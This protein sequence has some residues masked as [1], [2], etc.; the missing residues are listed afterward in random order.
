MPLSLTPCPLSAA[1]VQLWN[2]VDLINDF[3]EMWILHAFCSCYVTFGTSGSHH[4]WPRF[5]KYHLDDFL[6]CVWGSAGMG[7]ISFLKRGLSFRKKKKKIIF[8]HGA[9]LIKWLKLVRVCPIMIMGFFVLYFYCFSLMISKFE[10][11]SKCGLL[12]RYYFLFFSPK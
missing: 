10:L 12:P 2:N 11:P 1:E 4:Q 7:Y 5:E 8:I 6:H 3:D 9:Q